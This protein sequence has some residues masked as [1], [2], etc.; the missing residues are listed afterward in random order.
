M[1]L[2]QP[3]PASDVLSVLAALQRATAASVAAHR[4]VMTSSSLP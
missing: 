2:S 1:T 4:M 3:N